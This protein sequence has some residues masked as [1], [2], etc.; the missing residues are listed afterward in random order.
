MCREDLGSTTRGYGM[1]PVEEFENFKEFCRWY[2]DIIPEE[3][4]NL[5][6]AATI[7]FN[8]EIYNIF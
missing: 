7:Y 2:R 5:E 4:L 8:L 3:P 6:E 1:L